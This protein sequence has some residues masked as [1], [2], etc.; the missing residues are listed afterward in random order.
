MASLSGA[1][2]LSGLVFLLC[3]L[4][5]GA[6]AGRAGAYLVHAAVV[7]GLL[8]LS[9]A[10]LPRGNDFHETTPTTPT[11]RPRPPPPPSSSTPDSFP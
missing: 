4:L 11:S 5:A 8:F 10:Y 6:G 9:L 2:Q 7:A 3:S 1:F